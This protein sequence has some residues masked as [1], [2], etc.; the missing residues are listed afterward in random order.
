MASEGGRQLALQTADPRG[1]LVISIRCKKL[2][3]ICLFCHAGEL[4]IDFPG[5]ERGYLEPSAVFKGIVL[6]HG[7]LASAVGTRVVMG[8]EG[9]CTMTAY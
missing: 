4:K 5:L 6:R 1:L 2:F 3:N 9:G 8:T 7:V